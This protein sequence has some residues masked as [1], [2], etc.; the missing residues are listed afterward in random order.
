[1]RTVQ[2]R[3]PSAKRANSLNAAQ[4]NQPHRTGNRNIPAPR[5]ATLAV[6]TFNLLII[7]FVWEAAL[8]QRDKLANLMGNAR[9]PSDPWFEKIIEGGSI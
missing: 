5:Q 9:R 2:R 1:M 6:F 7:D 8:A 4:H 3:A